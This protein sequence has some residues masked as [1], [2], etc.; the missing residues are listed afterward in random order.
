MVLLTLPMFIWTGALNTLGVAGANATAT[1]YIIEH[2]L[3]I[4]NSCKIY[5]HTVTI[6]IADRYCTYSKDSKDDRSEHFKV[7]VKYTQQ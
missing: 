6:I 7:V 2:L 3:F 1:A 4:I 5:I